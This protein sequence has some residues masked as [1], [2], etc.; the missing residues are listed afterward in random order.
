MHDELERLVE[1][2]R[3]GIFNEEPH[4]S[5]EI[6]DELAAILNEHE[7]RVCVPKEPTEAML[8]TAVA[9]AL[10]VRISADYGW[11]PYM[12]DLWVRMIAAA[13]KEVEGE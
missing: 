4:L 8:D 1:R 13:P 3:S 11:T 7:G 10:N 2:I 9:F 5:G 12:R 6:A